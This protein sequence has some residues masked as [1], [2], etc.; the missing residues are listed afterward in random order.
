MHQSMS[1]LLYDDV[2]VG[3]SLCNCMDLHNMSASKYG[4]ITESVALSQRQC[5]CNCKYLH[6]MCESK[7]E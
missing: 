1:V 7:Y 5:V 6:N 2:G 4:R 3:D